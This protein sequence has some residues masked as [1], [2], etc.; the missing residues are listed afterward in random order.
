M[1]KSKVFLM[2]CVFCSARS[3][4]FNS[5]EFV[6]FLSNHHYLDGSRLVSS[7]RD[8]DFITRCADCFT[9][10]DVF[11]DTTLH[12]F[13]DNIALIVAQIGQFDRAAQILLK[14]YEE[15][16][17]DDNWLFEE[18]KQRNEDVTARA[19]KESLIDAY[20]MK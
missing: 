1:L 3:M 12:S 11:S 9:N 14:S 18:I 2:F 16:H 4:N 17:N 7:Q 19:I 10:D 6:K 13:V 20:G 8:K 5:V 15:D